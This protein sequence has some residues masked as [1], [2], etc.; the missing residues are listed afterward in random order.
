V[1]RHCRQGALEE[2]SA[3]IAA[4]VDNNTHGFTVIDWIWQG[5]GAPGNSPLSRT[6]Q[7]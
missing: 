6:P 1:K 3:V 2:T 5:G 4:M 7:Y